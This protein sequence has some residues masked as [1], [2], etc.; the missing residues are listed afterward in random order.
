MTAYDDGHPLNYGVVIVSVAGKNLKTAFMPTPRSIPMAKQF[1]YMVVGVNWFKAGSGFMK[2]D[3]LYRQILIALAYVQRKEKVELN[4]IGYI[5]FS[6]GAAI[7]YEIAYLDVRKWHLFKLF[8][9]HSGGIPTDFRVEP[10]NDAAPRDPFFANLSQGRLGSA[11]MKDTAFFLYSGDRD[12]EWGLKMSEQVEN[13]ENLIK[14]N[15]GTVVERVRRADLGHM[16]LRKDCSIN[17]KAVKAFIDRT[18]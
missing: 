18:P 15:G 1:D 5:G 7:S 6:R 11:P 3:E 14:A 10:K 16:G 4:K 12:E 2:A 8:I 17:E 13:A 9:A